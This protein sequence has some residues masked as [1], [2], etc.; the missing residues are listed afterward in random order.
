M[1]RKGHQ[2]RRK[3]L[4][5][6]PTANTEYYTKDKNEGPLHIHVSAPNRR[7][8]Q[9]RI[10]STILQEA[11]SLIYGER[12]KHYRH[13]TEN[14]NNIAN[15]WNAYFKAILVRPG[16]SGSAAVFQINNIDIAYLNILQ[17]IARGATN[18][19]HIDSVIDIAG[20]A[21][22]IERVLKNK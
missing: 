13:P 9:R 17:K 11:E 14:F 16:V 18:Q 5:N 22:C 15:L 4:L 1:K 21:G 10:P 12:N 19:E 6:D 3:E 8:L 7:K 20:Y 2:Q